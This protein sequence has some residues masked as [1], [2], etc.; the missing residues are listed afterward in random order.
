MRWGLT[1]TGPAAA[2]GQLDAHRMSAGA[3]SQTTRSVLGRPKGGGLRVEIAGA[4]SFRAAAPAWRDL[5]SRCA[6]P[7][8]F[9]E[10]GV[11]EA[12]QSTTDMPLFSILAWR[13]EQELEGAWLL[14]LAKPSSHL[15]VRVLACPP[16]ALTFLGSPVLDRRRPAETLSAMFDAIA[17]DPGLPKMLCANDIAAEGAVYPALRAAID[18]RGG[19]ALEIE[20]R[21]RAK[22]DLKA[23]PKDPSN[24]AGS[25]KRRSELRRQRKKLAGLG[26]L[27]HARYSAPDA[28]RA[29]FGEFLSLEAAGWKGESRAI[30]NS[31]HRTAFAQDMIERLARDGCV[32]IDALRLDGRAIAMNVW[33]RSGHG[34]FGWKM[35]FDEAYRQMSPGAL[36]L[37]DL[38]EQVMADPEAWFFDSCNRRDTGPLAQLWP[39][40][41]EILDLVIDLHPGGSLRGKCLAKLEHSYRICRDAAR[42]RILPVVDG[43][44]PPRRRRG[45]K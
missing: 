31:E 35:A 3:W 9:M 1:D 43:L 11:A 15:P 32:A 5:V 23:G 30:L 22:L 27:E 6:E 16:N 13:S 38:T 40:R 28:V 29:A 19:T 2:G 26:T 33:L 37:D 36:L 8:V 21:A 4:E 24:R 42:R 10:P 17:A 25:S 45:W 34:V 20:R 12:V 44:I 7:N 39:E 41:R 14:A 18:E